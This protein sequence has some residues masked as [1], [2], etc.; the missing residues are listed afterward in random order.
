MRVFDK[1]NQSAR[2]KEIEE[3]NAQVKHFTHPAVSFLPVF[4][5]PSFLTV[6]FLLFFFFLSVCLSLFLSFLLS[7]LLPFL[8]P[9]FLS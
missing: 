3:E 2:G 5:S 7:F 9:F 8:L 4:L 6:S 1:L